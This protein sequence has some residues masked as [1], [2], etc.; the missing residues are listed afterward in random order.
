MLNVLRA[1]LFSVAL[2][3][4]GTAS[5]NEHATKDDAVAMVH[6]VIAYIKA[7]GKDKAI[8]EVNIPKGRFVD[9][10]LYVAV[11]DGHGMVLAHGGNPRLVGKNLFEVKDV[12]GKAFVKDGG[13]ILKTKNSCW[14]DYKWPN[15]VSGKIELKSLYSEKFNDL[16]I[17]VGVYQD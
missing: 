4:T 17:S 12:D 6:N 15:P 13:E 10:D 5:A 7:N 16:V 11:G 8:A 1:M 3:V 14:V 2:A 9:R